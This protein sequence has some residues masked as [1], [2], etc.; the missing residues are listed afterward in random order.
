MMANVI[1]GN[2]EPDFWM[3]KEPINAEVLA[4]KDLAKAW[5]K[6]IK[7]KSSW[8]LDELYVKIEAFVNIYPSLEPLIPYDR[9]L[10]KK[11]RKLKSEFTTELLPWSKKIELRNQKIYNQ[12]EKF[13]K[14][15]PEYESRLPPKSPFQPHENEEVEIKFRFLLQTFYGRLRDRDIQDNIA[16]I[17]EAYCELETFAEDNCIDI[18]RLPTFY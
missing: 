2:Q 13:V 9:E 6:E 1:I 7:W 14:T 18:Q 12:L 17:E 4:F 8:Y 5:K 16:R 10:E 15:H 3:V 11:F